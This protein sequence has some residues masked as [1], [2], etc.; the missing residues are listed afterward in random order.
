MKSNDPTNPQRFGLIGDLFSNAVDLP[1][2]KRKAYLDLHCEG[3][4]GLRVEVEKMLAADQAVGNRLEKIIESQA[5]NVIDSGEIATAPVRDPAI[6]QV[7]GHYRITEAI[8]AGGMGAVYKAERIDEEFSH[9]VAIKIVGNRVAAAHTLERLR[10]ERQILASLAHE[11][12]ARLHDGGTTEEG[13]P[14]IVMEYIDGLPIDQYCDQNK[15]SIDQRIELFC[16]VCAGVH[17]AHQ[18]LVVHRDIK[19]SNILVASDGTPK[20]LDFGIAK[21]IDDDNTSGLT[22]ADQRML[23]PEY[24]SPEH[25]AG[26]M[27][28]TASDTYSLGVLLYKL[29][30]GRLP[31]RFSGKSYAEL[32]HLVQETDPIPPSRAWQFESSQED[33]PTTREL[34]EARGSTPERCARTL[35]GDLDNIIQ[36]ALRKEPERRYRSANQL[37]EDLRRREMGLPVAARPDTW[38]YRTGKFIRRH[39]LGMVAGSL[40]AIG[41]VVFSGLLW[42]GGQR[43]ESALERAED[44]TAFLVELFEQALPGTLSPEDAA[45]LIKLLQNSEQR[46]R[47]EYAD[48]PELRADLMIA[49]SKVYRSLSDDEA[50]R[51]LAKE[52]LELIEPISESSDERVVEAKLVLAQSLLDGDDDGGR[53]REHAVSLIVDALAGARRAQATEYEARAQYLYGVAHVNRRDYDE[54]ERALSEGIAML[55]ELDGPDLALLAELNDALGQVYMVTDPSKAIGIYLAMEKLNNRRFDSRYYPAVWVNFHNL[56]LSQL[57][58]GQLDQAE[59]NIQKALDVM[60]QIYPANHRDYSAVYG[61]MSRVQLRKRCYESAVLYARKA[62][63]VAHARMADSMHNYAYAVVDLGNAQRLAGQLALA[64]ASYSEAYEIQSTVLEANDRMLASTLYWHSKLYV[65]L[66][67]HDRARSKLGEALDIYGANVEGQDWY[68]ARAQA[69]MGYIYLAENDL[70]ESMRLL[71]PATQ[72]LLTEA[73]GNDARREAIGWSAD[74]YWKLERTRDAQRMEELLTELPPVA[75]MSSCANPISARVGLAEQEGM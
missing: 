4:P 23:T 67:Q 63:D 3:D 12:I 50:A 64:D 21:L 11:N 35:R 44:A 54:A 39:T 51:R 56:G 55:A 1:P 7:L 8:G 73:P 48:Q 40:A 16:A 52:G 27:I 38:G 24:A 59:K 20:L 53:Q 61:S 45:V 42:V 69:L 75:P 10:A 36:M 26:G 41:L 43:T 22:A 29:L 49:L 65:D 46:L 32:L 58:A 71:K 17:H 74:L 57:Y 66:G 5:I 18:S 14:Y 15:L 62:R 34:A 33:Q 30:A 9:S 25:I 6:G 2:D 70:Q 31:Y 72:T 13:I 37:A 47:E 28:T 60:D 19:P 68:H